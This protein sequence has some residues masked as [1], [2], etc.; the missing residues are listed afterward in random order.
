MG[1]D[2][3][4][5]IGNTPLIEL[6]RLNPNPLVT[7]LAK[8]EFFNPSGSIKDR[9]AHHIICDAERR[10]VLKRGGIIIDATSGN[11]GASI[12]MIAALKGYRALLT[13]PDKVSKEKI[14]ALRAYG[15]EVVICPTAAPPDSSLHYQEV[16]KRLAGQTPNSFYLNQHDNLKNAEAHYCTT[17]PELWAQI[18]GVIDYFVA[19]AG[20]GG[21][22]S[23]VAKFLKEKNPRIR[24]IMPDPVGSLYYEFFKTGKV[25]AS[26]GC[27]YQVEGI[28]GD[29][30]PRNLEFSL[31]DEVYQCTDTEAFDTARRLAKEEGLLVGGSSG[32][33]VW[34]CVRLAQTLTRK[35]VI[36]TILPDSGIKYLS[37]FF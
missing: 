4:Q 33:N 31:I 17:G 13:V 29:H 19:A 15:A 1:K 8:C 9:M 10:G 3:E 32:V 18:G 2:I 25:E 12:A 11:T 36:V 28:G 35:A 14:D 24:V 20:T 21:T 6:R 5:T 37:K 16:A 34:A 26:Q 7:I 22:I 27:A 30:L 23:G